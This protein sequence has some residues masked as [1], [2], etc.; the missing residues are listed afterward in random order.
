MS[1]AGFVLG[2]LVVGTMRHPE[3]QG[4]VVPA[5]TWANGLLHHG[6]TVNLTPWRA[7][8]SLGL[9]LAWRL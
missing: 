7:S 4:L 2:S 8:A 5:R 6:V 3:G 9:V 1:R